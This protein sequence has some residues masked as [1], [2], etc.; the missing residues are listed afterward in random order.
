MVGAITRKNHCS[1]AVIFKAPMQGCSLENFQIC[2][3]SMVVIVIAMICQSVKCKR[4]LPSL[5]CSLKNPDILLNIRILQNLAYLTDDP[6]LTL[7]QLVVTFC[8]SVI[9]DY[10]L[11]LCY[12]SILVTPPIHYALTLLT[13]ISMHTNFFFC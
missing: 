7:L 6:F 9:E 5:L 12:I 8:T 2:R 11:F 13:N 3:E 1:C 4:Y 10:E